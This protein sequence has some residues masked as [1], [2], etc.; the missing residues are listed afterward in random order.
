MLSKN[1]NVNYNYTNMRFHL[2]NDI[3][4]EIA[5]CLKHFSKS[6]SKD[7]KIIF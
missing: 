5:I 6:T 7:Q 1:V 4:I 3:S 2:M